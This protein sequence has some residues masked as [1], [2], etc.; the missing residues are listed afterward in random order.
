MSQHYPNK[1]LDTLVQ[2]HTFCTLALNEGDCLPSGSGKFT[3]WKRNPAL[4]CK[5]FPTPIWICCRRQMFLALFQ[6]AAT[7]SRKVLS[8]SKEYSRV[9]YNEQFL[10]IKLGW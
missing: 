6:T 5:R 8:V 4:S 2:I 10:S 3:H 7:H 9:C 1:G